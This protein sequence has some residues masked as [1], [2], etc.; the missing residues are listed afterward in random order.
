MVFGA[1]GACVVGLLTLAIIGLLSMPRHTV[2][3]DAVLAR[4]L[5]RECDGL[6]DYRCTLGA[7]RGDSE[8][9]IENTLEAI[10]SA[11]SDP[12]YAFI[13]CDVQ[14]AADGTV[15]VFH[16]RRLRRVFGSWD[17]IGASTYD[18]LLKLSGGGIA[19]YQEVMD[20]ARGKRLNIEIKSQGD[21]DEDRRLVDFVVADIQARGL[22]KRVAIS[23]I[24]EDVV[25]YAKTTYPNLAVGQVFWVKSST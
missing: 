16:D 15:V 3:L 13:E 4:E 17:K 12:R 18:E 2:G 14:Y 7:H 23:S 11:R 5:G 19:T 9:H 21:A 1:V 6:A 8:L 24:S 22:L 25:A 10:L 20:A